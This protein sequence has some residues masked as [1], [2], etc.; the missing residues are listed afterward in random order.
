MELLL[1][2]VAD[3]GVVYAQ[4]LMGKHYCEGGLLWSK[5]DAKAKEWLTKAAKAGSEEAREYLREKYGISVE[6]K[7]F[8]HVDDT[9]I[10]NDNN[11]IIEFCGVP[12]IDG[13]YG[14]KFWVYNSNSVQ[15]TIWLKNCTVN[16]ESY[17]TITKLNDYEPNHGHYGIYMIDGINPSANTVITIEFELDDGTT[18]IATLCRLIVNLIGRTK[19]VSF[20]TE[21]LNRFAEIEDD[22]DYE[23]TTDGFQDEVI[24]DEDVHIEF[25]GVNLDYDEECELSF[26]VRNLSGRDISIWARNVCVDGEQREQFVK[27]GEFPNGKSRFDSITISDINPEEYYNIHLELEVNDTDNHTLYDAC[28]LSFSLDGDGE[29]DFA[30][31][32][33]KLGTSASPLEE[34]DEDEDEN[35]DE[36]EEEDE[37]E[38]FDRSKVRRGEGSN[39][40]CPGSWY[41]R[42]YEHNGIEIYFP[43]KPPAELRDYLKVDGWRWF[44]SKGCWYTYYSESNLLTA[45]MIT[46][47]L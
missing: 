45:K 16:G 14:L 33:E 24:Y 7:E 39:L 15:R 34:E 22:T 13:R 12:L 38:D 31:E 11:T 20:S 47:K 41:A 4:F 8:Q 25:C 26:W 37:E 42:N 5:N 32:Y 23:L 9:R 30:I 1:K 46:G 19:R 44:Q 17:G 29:S 43:E 10:Y 27:L 3:A 21:V 35:E 28:S 2:P 6:D 18:E 36:D 40:F